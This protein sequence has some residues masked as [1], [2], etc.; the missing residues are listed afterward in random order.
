MN[1]FFIPENA[2]IVAGKSHGKLFIFFISF[3]FFFLSAGF[4]PDA[5]AQTPGKLK[6]V[7]KIELL[8]EV[9]PETEPQAM[10]LIN[11]LKKALQKTHYVLKIENGE[12]L[13]AK[14]ETLSRSEDVLF[15]NLA[16]ISAGLHLATY[17]NRENNE[18]VI[19]KRG[20][21]K[22]YLVTTDLT[23]F[24]WNLLPDEKTIKGLPARK[25]EG[26]FTNDEGEEV[27]VTAWYST[28]IPFQSGP[29]IFQGLPGF[30]LE[31][32]FRERRI[33]LD[34][35][36]LDPKEN[37]RIARP[38]KGEHATEEEI[39]KKNKKALDNIGF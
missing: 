33:S 4:I 1:G 30:I 23:D 18:Q 2:N 21:G 15:E 7:Y 6:A 9:S 5:S 19:R 22:I 10:A 16:D 32:E 17:T 34:K 27:G 3:V 26:S 38:E 20:L 25:A 24:N 29:D 13:F 39:N 8:R 14:D 36:E 35:L 12:S 37:F 11:K 31:V 28:V